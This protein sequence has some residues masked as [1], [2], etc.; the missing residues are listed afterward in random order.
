[1][2]A[3]PPDPISVLLE[4]RSDDMTPSLRALAMLA[5]FWIGIGSFAATAGSIALGLVVSMF[6]AQRVPFGFLAYFVVALPCAALGY[7]GS[8]KVRALAASRIARALEGR[9]DAIG[10][11]SSSAAL[12]LR[13]IV[14]R[15]CPHEHVKLDVLA[16]S[17]MWRD[18][19]TRDLKE[20]LAKDTAPRF[21]TVTKIRCGRC[22]CDL[23]AE[24]DLGERVRSGGDLFDPKIGWSSPMPVG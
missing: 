18:I 21:V 22:A 10:G 16:G 5:Q 6:L 20:V 2:S 17:T 4:Q 3:P 12:P 7:L 14:W 11:A 8:Q 13:M 24:Q 15:G 19:D 1:M 23:D 9:L